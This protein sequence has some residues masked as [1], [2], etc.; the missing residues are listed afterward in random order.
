MIKAIVVDSF[1]NI[2][3]SWDPEYTNDNINRLADL[4]FLLRKKFISTS[5]YGKLESSTQNWYFSEL[6][7]NQGNLT[8]DLND[9]SLYIDPNSRFSFD[10]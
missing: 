2:N 8:W 5:F 1:K 6:L 4:K 3:G 7:E 9:K 10:L